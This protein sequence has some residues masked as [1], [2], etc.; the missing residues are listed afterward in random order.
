M[1]HPLPPWAIHGACTG[2]IGVPAPLVLCTGE[3]P[4]S[5]FSVPHR[6]DRV[7]QGR[8]DL[9]Q[10]AGALWPAAR[11]VRD[12]GDTLRAD[13][14]PVIEI[15]GRAYHVPSVTAE[16]VGSGPAAESGYRTLARL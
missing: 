2:S 11:G 8:G 13:V 10:A 6:R 5:L 14:L 4:F 7:A 15:G 12:G 16:A 9:P 1:P 3:E